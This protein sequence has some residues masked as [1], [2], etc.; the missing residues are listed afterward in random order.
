MEKEEVWRVGED[1]RAL[2][3]D[4]KTM[5]VKIRTLSKTSEPLKIPSLKAILI[6]E[7]LKRK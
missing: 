6:R 1:V 2:T 7:F 4:E 5:L 3:M